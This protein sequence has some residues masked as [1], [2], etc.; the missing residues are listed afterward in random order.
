[1]TDLED[2]VNLGEIAFDGNNQE[3]KS[4]SCLGQTCSRSLIVFLSLLYVILLIIFGCFWRIHLSKT[5]DESTVWVGN[6]CNAAGYTLHSP[7]LWTSYILWKI[8]SWFYWLVPQKLKSLSLFTIVQKL[9][10]F[11]QSL[12]KYT[13]PINIANLFTML[14]KNKLKISSLYRE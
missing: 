13:F 6:F 9:E 14:C 1:M 11:K 4:W 5:C 7:R 3:R 10:H 12:T 2:K 8:E